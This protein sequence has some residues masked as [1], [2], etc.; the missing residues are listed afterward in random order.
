MPSPTSPLLSRR[1]SI[2][3]ADDRIDEW[4]DRY[5]T[6]ALDHVF[7]P[8]SSA[9]DHS[10]LWLVAG[11]VRSARGGHHRSAQSHSRDGD[12]VV[13]DE[14]RG[15]VALPP[16]PAPRPI[17]GPL[18]YGMHTPITSSFPSGHATAAFCA[19]ALLGDRRRS[20]PAW[21]ALAG[22]VAASRVYVRMHH[23]SDVVAGAAFGWILGSALRRRLPLDGHPGR[24]RSHGN[25]T[26]RRRG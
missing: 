26:V 12:R 23:A 9:A 10:L 19:A 25:A 4:V 14:R 20:A 7:Y 13:H 24:R 6:P 3:E 21:Y 1:G 16:R 15:Q 11:A 17:E 5:R 8:L 2:A 18:P 22:A